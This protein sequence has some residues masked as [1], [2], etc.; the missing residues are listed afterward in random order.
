MHRLP[1]SLLIAV[2]AALTVA[3]CAGGPTSPTPVTSGLVVAQVAQETPSVPTALIP[4]PPNAV[5]AA[6]FLAFAE[7]AEGDAADLSVPGGGGLLRTVEPGP[8]RQVG[9]GDQCEARECADQGVLHWGYVSLLFGS[10]LRC[11]ITNSRAVLQKPGSSPRPAFFPQS[12]PG[13]SSSVSAPG[14]SLCPVA[15]HALRKLRGSAGLA[16]HSS[17]IAANAPGLR[18]HPAGREGLPR[19]NQA[20][21]QLRF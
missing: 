4:T 5:G 18:A 10:L 12:A 14:S 3:G 8:G 19:S 21:V 13:A 6:R 11:N 20:G 9:R 7:R 17:A 1:N 15:A 16:G 2:A